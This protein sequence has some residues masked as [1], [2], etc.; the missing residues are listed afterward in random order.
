MYIRISDESTGLEAWLY[1]SDDFYYKYGYE[2]SLV[3]GYPSHIANGGGYFLHSHSGFFGNIAQNPTAEV[4]VSQN[5]QDF[6]GSQLSARTITM[7]FKNSLA[8]LIGGTGTAMNKL[9]ALCEITDRSVRVDVYGTEKV[10]TNYFSFDAETDTEGGIIQMTS[11]EGGEG[12]YWSAGS[13]DVMARFFE[14]GIN[15]VAKDFPAPLLRELD[16]PM[17]FSYFSVANAAPIIKVGCNPLQG[18]WEHAKIELNGVVIEYDNAAHD[19]F[20]NIDTGA[21]TCRNQDGDNVL[22]N[23]TVTTWPQVMAGNNVMRV[24]LNGTENW[25][26]AERYLGQDMYIEVIFERLTSGV[27]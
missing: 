3:A 25:D 5:G 9:N 1:E 15:Y 22:D 12:V 23:L 11:A 27:E 2:A 18:F 7:N 26:E 14:Q 17:Q 8:F 4:G 24:T 16:Y 10:F 20:I 13:I 6:T 19:E 21:L